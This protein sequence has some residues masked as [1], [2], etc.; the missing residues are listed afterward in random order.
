MEA[1][2]KLKEQRILRFRLCRM[3]PKEPIL[4]PSHT[5]D[6]EANK[7]Y[8]PFLE[9]LLFREAVYISFGNSACAC[10]I[11]FKGD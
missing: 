2:H 1:C 4:P 10:F 8:T 9:V 6:S 7:V 3:L 5:Q 11:F